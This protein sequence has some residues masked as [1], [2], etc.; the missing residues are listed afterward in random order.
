MQQQQLQQ[1][2]LTVHHQKQ[3]EEQGHSQQ[4]RDA[5]QA[6]IVI[7]ALGLCALVLFMFASSRAWS[8]QGGLSLR[9]GSGSA[10][11]ASS[12]LLLEGEQ[13]VV[14]RSQQ[15][16]VA[17]DGGSDGIG[18]DVV[19]LEAAEMAM[20]ELEQELVENEDA[21]E[22][23]L[24][25]APPGDAD[26]DPETEPE[27]DP[28]PESDKRDANRGSGSN[29]SLDGLGNSTKPTVRDPANLVVAGL[30]DVLLLGSLTA[31]SRRVGNFSHL[32]QPVEHLW[33]NHAHHAFANF[34]GCT[35]PVDKKGRLVTSRVPNMWDKT[36]Y[37]TGIKSGGF[38][39]HPS[40]VTALAASGIDVMTT[41]N[42][43][44]FDRG[45]AGVRE[46]A[47]TLQRAG[48]T[49]IGSLPKPGM[50]GDASKEGWYK[51]TRKNGWTVAWIGCTSILCSECRTSLRATRAQVRKQIMFCDKAPEVVRK[52]ARR[53]DVDAVVV[54]A[55]W[56]AQFKDYHTPRIAALARSILDA[57]AAAIIGNHPHVLQDAEFYTTKPDGRQT[58]VAYSLGSLTSGLGTP[59]WLFK[60]RASAVLFLEL[61]KGS[62]DPRTG[63]K[64]TAHVVRVNYVPICEVSVPGST[65]GRIARREMRATSDVAPLNKCQKEE[66][67]ARKL[68]GAAY[69]TRPEA[70][71]LLRRDL[72][73]IVV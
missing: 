45:F 4:Q 9:V 65:K 37:D 11:V 70:L 48:I 5:R 60:R 41:A 3:Q 72:A 62:V 12:A 46:T 6:R 33:R 44:A 24:D 35:G 53:A 68:L 26:P 29:L 69:M 66:R 58:F 49:Q 63:K 15:K 47:L 36:V 59:E 22:V 43:H 14:V 30:G 42:N 10:A 20:E 28:D 57:G 38:N 7:P 16:S 19:E 17:E 27:P 34:E 64:R 73:R 18:A 71:P 51:L 23:R 32:W 2:Q 61:A 39:Y 25:D 50:E 67:W 52:L 21:A 55:H 13:A 40:L 8:R 31:E 56:G 1:Q 54:G